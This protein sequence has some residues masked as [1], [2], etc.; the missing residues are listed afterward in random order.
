MGPEISSQSTM[1]TFPLAL[2]QKKETPADCVLG[3]KL[4]I[5]SHLQ[6]GKELKQKLAAQSQVCLVVVPCTPGDLS[7]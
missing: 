2:L 1:N 5:G 3:F 4:E 7:L 6:V